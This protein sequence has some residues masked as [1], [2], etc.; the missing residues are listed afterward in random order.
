M[1]QP[2]QQHQIV[3]V[4]QPQQQQIFQQQIQKPQIQIQLQQTFKVEPQQ[5]Q[6]IIIQKGSQLQLHQQHSEQDPLQQAGAPDGVSYTRCPQLKIHPLGPTPR[7][8]ASSPPRSL[9]STPILD[10]TAARK[11]HDFDFEYNTDKWV[12]S[13][14][15]R[16]RVQHRQVG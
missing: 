7:Q 13:W 9:I 10:H 1:K 11:R 15:S 3:Q 6:Q 2:Q 14:H 8:P 4:Q 12:K 5:Q 16:L